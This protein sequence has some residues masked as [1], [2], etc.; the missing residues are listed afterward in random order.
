MKIIIV[1]GSTLG[2]TMR[3]AVLAGTILRDKGYDVKV[4]D[5]RDS[6]I[7]ELKNF[8]LIIF[9]CST[10]DDGMLQFDFRE[11]NNQLM[12]SNLQ[13]LKFAVFGLG[14]H[15]YRHFCTAP[16]IIA[17][18][19]KMAKGEVVIEN[20]KL[21]LDHDEPLQLRD[22][23]MTEWVDKITLKFPLQ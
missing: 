23:E 15:K 8:D 14:G 10:W 4:K 19:I 16:D 3:L 2:K 18:S 1:F 9:G 11:F 17:S 20:L 22:K 5:V 7:D 13:N 12:H 6:T 21:D